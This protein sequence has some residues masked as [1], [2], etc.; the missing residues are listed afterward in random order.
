MSQ[1]LTQ[2]Q[3]ADVM[4]ISMQTLAKWRKAGRGPAFVTL[5]PLAGAHLHQGKG[6]RS[7]IRYRLEDIEAWQQTVSSA[8]RR[9][10]RP[11]E[12]PQVSPRLTDQ[13]WAVVRA[14]LLWERRMDRLNGN[15][16]LDLDGGEGARRQFEAILELSLKTGLMNPTALLQRTQRTGMPTLQNW[17]DYGWLTVGFRALEED[18]SFPFVMIEQ[19]LILA[20]QAPRS[21]YNPDAMKAV[22]IRTTFR[23]PLPPSGRPGRLALTAD[24]LPPLVDAITG[25]TAAASARRL[26]RKRDWWRRNL[27]KNGIRTLSLKKD[28]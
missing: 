27:G 2:N 25:V 4:A 8:A 20:H 5:D 6:R 24:D 15:L 16:D 9:V 19:T 26:K 1:L 22:P 7:N 28:V 11:L 17:V 14:A 3:A 18:K 12:A 21:D 23:G 10:P 13:Q